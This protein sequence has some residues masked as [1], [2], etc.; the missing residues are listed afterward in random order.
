MFTATSTTNLRSRQVVSSRAV[1]C[2]NVAQGWLD[3]AGMPGATTAPTA[4][5]YFTGIK[6]PAGRPP[7]EP[8]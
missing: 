6:H 3:T 1:R 7:E 4:R 5:T 8:M 2:T